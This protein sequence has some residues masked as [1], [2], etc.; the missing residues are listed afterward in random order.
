MSPEMRTLLSFFPPWVVASLLLGVICGAL[1]FVLAGRKVLSLPL[2]L[3]LGGVAAILGQMA[4]LALELQPWPVV[5][6][7][8]HVL[9]ATGGALLL[10][11]VA[12]L[13][14]L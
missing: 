7:Q 6:G 1:F 10:L 5:V 13:Y 11:F 14:R 8:L 3:V 9:A 12:R 2:Y 4:S